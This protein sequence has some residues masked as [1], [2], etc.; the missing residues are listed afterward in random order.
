M[1]VIA[2]PRTRWSNHPD[3]TVF[4][5]VKDAENGSYI[6]FNILDEAKAY[7]AIHY[8]HGT[9]FIFQFVG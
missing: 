9:H 2:K 7:E 5:F 4:D 8:P 3:S 6:T 1:F